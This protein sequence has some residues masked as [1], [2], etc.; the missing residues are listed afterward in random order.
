MCRW[1]LVLVS[2]GGRLAADPRS[3]PANSAAE[4]GLATRCA[5]QG[6]SK[7]YDIEMFENEKNG[8]VGTLPS[9]GYK[10]IR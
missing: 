1:R 6:K 5:G 8:V 3:E 9:K 7:I 10:V 4:M 2:D